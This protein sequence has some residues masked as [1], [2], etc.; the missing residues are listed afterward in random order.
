M[1]K[2]QQKAL[3]LAM[4]Q[5]TYPGITW[6]QVFT[7]GSAE[8]ATIIR[9]SGF[10]ICYPDGRKDSHSLPVGDNCTNFKAEA[11]ALIMAVQ[12]FLRRRPT[13]QKIVTLRNT[14]S[15]LPE[16]AALLLSESL[17]VSSSD[18]YSLLRCLVLCFLPCRETRS[19]ITTYWPSV[20][21]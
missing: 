10:H 20:H 19:M 18:V 14:I 12:H 7:D 15:F 4:R 11:T 6:T 9:G 17:M 2:A 8:G 13:E 1:P 21:L 5:D 3:S 16:S